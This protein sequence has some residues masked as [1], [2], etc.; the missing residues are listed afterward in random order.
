MG[1]ETLRYRYKADRE[2]LEEYK[3]D[4]EE[5]L[6]VKNVPESLACSDPYCADSSHSRERDSYMLDILCSVIESSHS[7]VPLAGGGSPGTGSGCLAGWRQ[8]VTPYQQNSKFWHAVWV[9]S[10]KPNTGEIHAAM[11]KSRNLYHYAVRKARRQS[12]LFKAKRLLEASL[13]GDMEL[14][15]EMK[16]IRSGGSGQ[17]EL[18]EKVAGA[19][20]E[21]AIVEK[22]REVY[23]GLYNSAGTA[24][25][26][27]VIKARLGDHI[28]QD[29]MQ[30]VMKITGESVKKAAGLMKCGKGDVSEGYSSDAILHGPDLLFEKL[31]AVF[32]SWCTHGTV[33]S[34]LLACAFL[35]LLKSSLK[36]PADPSSYRAIAGSSIILK[37]FDKVILLLWGHLLCTDSLQFGYKVGTSTTQCSWLV[38]EVANFYLRSGTQPIITLLDCSKAFDTCKF[39]ILFSR[40]IERGMPVLVTRVMIFV[41]EEQYAW[42]KWGNSKSSVFSILNG[43]RQGSI[44]S[45][46]LFALYVDELL[47]ELRTLG[48]G[49]HV[50]G[51][52]MGAFGFCDDLLLLAPTRDGM[53][54][55]LDSQRFALKYNLQFST[56]PN[57]AKSK[58][59]CI[60]VCG[61][62]KKAKKPVPL[63]LDGKCL[64]WVESAPHLGHVLHESGSMDQDIRVKRATFIDESTKIREAFEFAS[65][66]E[67]LRAV[68]VYVGS[69]YGSN[70]WQFDSNL[71]SQYFSAWRTCVKLAWQ[72][73]RS[74]HTYLVDHYL[75]C[76]LTSART[77]VLSR[78]SNFLQGLRNSSC[79]EVS[80]M[81]GV[82]SG[83]VQSTTG[84]NV[85]MIRIETALDPTRA[86]S[87][88]VRKALIEGTP[89]VPGREKWRLSYLGTLLQTRGEAHYAGKDTGL[90]T[91]L[92]DSL[93]SS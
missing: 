55:M 83:D 88:A 54:I 17:A 62:A 11:A 24:P 32:R 4:L 26:V 48:I 9:S 53:Q 81:L 44:L 47:V 50:A 72:L 82:V 61:K 1:L 86:T 12:D 3:V 76:G 2:V 77:D 21:A 67:V 5:R 70:L 43:T 56:D 92:I 22:F 6:S 90:I 87:F 58:T 57:P 79:M 29:S 59:K 89:P 60:F 84:Q 36:N 65:P 18:P 34:S 39:S 10:G 37:L 8:E 23:S 31:A 7:T 41:Y 63:V 52:F 46:A 66:W 40:L 33:T 80:V 68:K 75:S 27:Q 73:P 78:F 69:H 85:K 30:E 38:Q 51:V 16:K 91:T 42:V 64:P 25:E 28:N 20:G 74:T 45:P 13:A 19:E 93:C 71:A 35:P 14:L 49:C 15:R